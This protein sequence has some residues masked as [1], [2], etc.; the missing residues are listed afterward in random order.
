MED[1][2]L[3]KNRKLRQILGLS[4][5]GMYDDDDKRRAILAYCNDTIIWSQIDFDYGLSRR[6]LYQNVKLIAICFN[7]E[8]VKE[9][10]K[11]W[12]TDKNQIIE[13]VS[14]YNFKHRGKALFVTKNL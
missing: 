13:K 3:A 5:K 1:S 11:L 12:Q 7:F 2:E 14:A 6:A 9:L 4:I 10:K 8:D